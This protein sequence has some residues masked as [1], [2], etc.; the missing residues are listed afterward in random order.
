MAGA[1]QIHEE[2]VKQTSILPWGS[3]QREN[4][5]MSADF[6]HF[7]KKN[8]VILISPCILFPQKRLLAVCYV[9]KSIFNLILCIYCKKK[10]SVLL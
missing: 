1:A 6:T 8:A 5:L 7:N 9:R 3:H 10:Q 2:A 4:N